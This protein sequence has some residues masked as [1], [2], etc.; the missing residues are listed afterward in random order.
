MNRFYKPKLV[1]SI[2]KR[3]IQGILCDSTR[4]QFNE[5][6]HQFLEIRPEA[7]KVLF[8]FYESKLMAV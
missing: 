7:L 5:K 8:Y 4:I 2:S 3:N 1:K 6:H